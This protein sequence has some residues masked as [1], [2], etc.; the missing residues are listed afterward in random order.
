MHKRSV[1]PHRDTRLHS[2]PPVTPPNFS[3][4]NADHEAALYVQDSWKLRPRLTLNLGLR[5]E[6]FGPQASRNPNL[7]SNFYFGSG[8]NIELQSGTGQVLVSTDKANP[9]GGLWKKDWHDFG[10]R[11]GFAWDVFGNGKTSLRGGYGLGWN[12]N[13]GNVTFNVIQ[14][15]PNYSVIA[16]TAGSDV[17]TIPITTDNSGPWQ[18]PAAPSL[19]RG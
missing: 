19:S 17:P 6:Y 4:S 8:S 16:L 13:F 15:P 1:R 9:V 18:G 10:P 12:P 5:W 14:N 3:R 7:D 2:H 11:V